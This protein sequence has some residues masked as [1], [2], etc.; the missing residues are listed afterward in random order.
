[1]SR[2]QTAVAALCVLTL[3]LAIAGLLLSP[4]RGA[5]GYWCIALLCSAA[6]LIDLLRSRRHGGEKPRG[7]ELHQGRGP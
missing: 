2:I 6:C 4:S 5:T 1:M 7:D 3:L